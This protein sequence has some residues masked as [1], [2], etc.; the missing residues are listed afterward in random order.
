MMMLR[1]LLWMAMLT[2]TL[3]ARFQPG[4]KVIYSRFYINM[5]DLQTIEIMTIVK[6]TDQFAR[7]IYD[8]GQK[9]TTHISSIQ[10]I[11]N[12]DSIF[13]DSLVGAFQHQYSL[14]SLKNITIESVDLG[15]ALSENDS[16]Y[17][18]G[19]R[20]RLILQDVKETQ[21]EFETVDT[22]LYINPG[23]TLYGINDGK[24]DYY[25]VRAGGMEEQGVDWALYP[26]FVELF[27]KIDALRILKDEPLR[28]KFSR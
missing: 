10:P 1:V 28:L 6:I 14:D 20:Y 5:I 21:R 8:D 9:I 4:D 27:L 22:F 3:H 12:I 17:Y 16:I 23:M 24:P 7:L 26:L 11:F 15:G 13:R 2:L 19:Q 18:S 25:V